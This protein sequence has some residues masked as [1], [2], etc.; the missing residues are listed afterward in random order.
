MIRMVCPN[1]KYVENWTD[2]NG[3]KV[4]EC[5]YNPPTVGRD[6][7]NGEL[8]PIFPPVHPV[9]YCSKFESKYPQE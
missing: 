5:R 9:T 2:D 3:H 7:D 6:S 8:V 1:C 4:Y